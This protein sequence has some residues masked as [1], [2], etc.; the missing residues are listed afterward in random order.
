MKISR[1]LGKIAYVGTRII[2]KR[3][4]FDLVLCE[5]SFGDNSLSGSDQDTDNPP[6]PKMSR[7]SHCGGNHIVYVVW[8]Q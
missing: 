8:R 4:W 1:F 7:P 5:I 6:E 2:L 3:N